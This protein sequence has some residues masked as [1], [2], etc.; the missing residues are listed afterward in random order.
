MKTPKPAF[1][2]GLNHSLVLAYQRLEIEIGCG[3]GLHPV[4]RAALAKESLAMV[5]Q[6]QSTHN[7]GTTYYFVLKKT[8]KSSENENEKNEKE[9]RLE[10]LKN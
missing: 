10:K 5:V 9:P 1:A 7:F 2:E 3:V 8:K 4:A 6:E